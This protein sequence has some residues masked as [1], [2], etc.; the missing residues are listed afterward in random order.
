VLLSEVGPCEACPSEAAA[1]AA[2]YAAC[3][4]PVSVALPAVTR[5]MAWCGEPEVVAGEW[6]LLCEYSSVL[7]LPTVLVLR[8]APFQSAHTAA[9]E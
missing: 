4:G 1:R 7:L 9:Y 5:F 3:Y 6:G 2:F 8:R